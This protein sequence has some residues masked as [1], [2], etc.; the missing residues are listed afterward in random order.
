MRVALDAPVDTSNG[1]VIGSSELVKRLSDTRV[2][3]IGEEHTNSEF[4]R[5]E[6]RVIQALRANG[7]EVLLG[8]EMFPYSAQ[9]ALDDW[10]RGL[11]TEQGLLE[12]AE[13]YVNWSYPFSY[14]RDIFEYA[15]VQKIP[16]YGVNL[17]APTLRTIRT[18]GFEALPASERT[19]LPPRIDLTNAEHHQLFRAYFDPTD[20]LHSQLSPD[21][22]AAMYRVQVAWDS[23]MGWN[24][25]QALEAH[26]GPTAIMVV[27]LGSGHVAYGLGAAHQLEGQFAG[28]VQTL[29][30]V[31]VRDR[32]FAPVATVRASYADFVWGVP[33]QLRPDVPSLGV[34]LSGRLGP[35]PT[36]VIEV[37]PGSAAA[38]AGVRTGDVLLR[39]GATALTSITVLQ[40][41]MDSYRWG[42]ETTLELRRGDQTLSVSLLFRSE[43]E[44]EAAGA[45][46]DR[47]HP[48]R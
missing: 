41:C 9:P 24:A 29:I 39:L 11:L 37:E 2:L 36:A 35:N 8:L 48:T 31:A 10:N 30:P 47:K 43:P 25:A 28:K 46:K 45:D 26:A 12:K 40:Q 42:D 5:I 22:E 33:P 1:E 20:P 34:S 27:L 14:Y 38:L 23:A 13:W 17:P 19:H 7:R 44:E 21:Q 6:L 32:D 16:M 4:H 15:R 18:R 3:F